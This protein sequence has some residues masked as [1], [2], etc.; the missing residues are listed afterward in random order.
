MRRLQMN[1]R[2]FMCGRF[3][4]RISCTEKLPYR[5]ALQ[6]C[7][8]KRP[9]NRL[10]VWILSLP[11]VS[12]SL[13]EAI[14]AV[15]CSPVSGFCVRCLRLDFTRLVLCFKLSGSV[16]VLRW[17]PIFAACHR[18]LNSHPLSVFGFRMSP[19]DTPPGALALHCR[20]LRLVFGVIRPLPSLENSTIHQ[21]GRWDALLGRR[22]DDFVLLAADK[23]AFAYGAIKLSN[24]QDKG[25]KIGEKLYMY[26]IGESGDVANFGDWS[27][28]NLQ[29]YK[30]RNGYEL[31]PKA[32]HHWL[33]KS[34]ADGL[35]S[36]DAW[37]V[38]LLIGGFDDVEKKPFLGSV[39]YLGNGLSEQP[40]LF[41]GFSGR[42]CYAIMD[43]FYRKDMNEEQ[44]M[45][46]MKKCLGEAKKRFM[47]SLPNFSIVK[48]DKNG[49]QHMADVELEEKANASEA[50]KATVVPCT[51]G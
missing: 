3:K 24:D 29:L 14:D 33:R 34:I 32:A 8:C 19:R 49:I 1:L 2:C 37:R 23:S 30:F 18:C 9:A 11:D 47:A 42:F 40:F 48:V 39:D 45:E 51:S 41:R 6:I 21:N 36:Q 35:R 46:T 10:L 31:G 13:H 17:L 5:I 50:A 4:A 27:T 38:D 15:G 44:A 22:C 16:G 26:C 7:S 20:T 12:P 43:K 25:Y 28:R